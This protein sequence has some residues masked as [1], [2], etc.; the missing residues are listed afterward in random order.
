MNILN[1]LF[2]NIKKSH[3]RFINTIAH[4]DPNDV[5]MNMFEAENNICVNI[6]HGCVC[7][8]DKRHRCGKGNCPNLKDHPTVDNGLY[9][10]Y[11]KDPI[12][13]V[14]AITELK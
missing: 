1:V 9:R 8:N 14:Q 11:I 3:E 10:Q 6:E 12:A 7:P 13:F 4:P 5:G 2:N